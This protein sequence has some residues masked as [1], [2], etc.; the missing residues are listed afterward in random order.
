[1]WSLCSI[2]LVTAFAGIQEPIVHDELAQLVQ[3]D[4]FAHGRLAEPPHPFWQ[5]FETIHVLSQ[6]N[7]QAKFPPAPA[8]FMAAG[9]KLTGVPIAG[10]WMS[11]V[12]M[13]AAVGYAMHALL[14]AH[15]AVVGTAFAALQFGIVGDWSHSYLGGAV[16]AAGGALVIGSAVRLL[17]VPRVRDAALLGVGLV[18]LALSRPY[19]G[20]AY[21]LPSVAL[22]AW[23]ACRPSPIRAALCRHAIP[24]IVAI[25]VLGAGWLAYYNW[26][27]T[28]SPLTLPYA[29]YERTY[30]S[31][32]LFVWQRVREPAPLYRNA[33][34]RNFE[35]GFSMPRALLA[36]RNWPLAQLLDL[37]S[38]VLKYLA[39]PLPLALLGLVAVP[40]AMRTKSGIAAASWASMSA[41]LM[42]S[43]WIAP[44]YLA[45]ATASIFALASVGMAGLW[46]LNTRWV[47]GRPVAILMVMML[48]AVV[49]ATSVQYV[50][51][52]RAWVG[53][54]TAKRDLTQQ[55]LHLP[56]NDL[57]FVRYKPSHS[58]HVEWV[59]NGADIDHQP[60][61]WARELDAAANERLRNYFADRQAWV[62]LAD[63]EPPRIVKWTSEV[64]VISARL[65]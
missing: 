27:V 31:A 33:E 17:R 42:M 1:M 9:E 46:R 13:I 16:A 5:H 10:V 62:V 2:V 18:L 58:P 51:D 49:G 60:I 63:E 43:C 8:L 53:W 30:S 47:A 54:W 7:Y 61:V 36:Q 32:P 34:M 6:P 41:A 21:S 38:G 48:V 45:P 20:L 19:E 56:G 28:G 37:A 11:V 23:R 3:A 14:P 50:A 15:W 55:L 52:N 65:R 44:R 35:R 22:V 59:Y 24:A 12:L 26:R 64:P 57:V 25:S 29:V 4:I 40:R 39:V